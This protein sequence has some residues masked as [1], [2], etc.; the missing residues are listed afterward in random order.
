MSVL[1]LCKTI[2]CSFLPPPIKL[3]VRQFPFDFYNIRFQRMHVEN[4]DMYANVV[5]LLDEFCQSCD[6]F[7]GHKLEKMCSARYEESNDYVHIHIQSNISTRLEDP[8]IKVALKSFLEDRNI[9]YQLVQDTLRVFYENKISYEEFYRTF[10]HS[11]VVVFLLTKHFY[12]SYKFSKL[13]IE[14]VRKGKTIFLVKLEDFTFDDDFDDSKNPKGLIVHDLSKHASDCYDGY[15]TRKFL[16]D[17]GTICSTDFVSIFLDSQIS[18]PTVSFQR[19]SSTES[20][21]MFFSFQWI[22]WKS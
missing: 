5:H 16:D 4:A 17:L 8:R 19:K 6:L 12:K 22:Q 9:D 7:R 11:S 2:E 21:T 1:Q 10:T 20:L 3:A 13:F 18:I 15:L 14:A